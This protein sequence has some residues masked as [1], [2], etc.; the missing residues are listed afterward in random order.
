VKKRGDFSKKYAKIWRFS[1]EF[2]ELPEC[3]KVISER[4]YG[5]KGGVEFKKEQNFFILFLIFSSF[6]QFILDI[7]IALY[8][9]RARQKIGEV[10]ILLV[11]KI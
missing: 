7:G 11:L 6:W 2:A 10:Y 1:Q 9:F 3:Y 8:I 4:E 5:E